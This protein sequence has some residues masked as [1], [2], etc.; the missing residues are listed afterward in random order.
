MSRSKKNQAENLID[1]KLHGFF[2]KKKI[3]I[4]HDHVHKLP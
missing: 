3:E 4:K 1:K 2:E